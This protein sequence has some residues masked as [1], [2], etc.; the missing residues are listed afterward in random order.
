VVA[1][2][3]GDPFEEVNATGRE[4]VLTTSCL[5]IEFRPDFPNEFLLREADI[6]DELVKGATLF[7][8]TFRHD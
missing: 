7:R 6:L 2:A 8:M 1:A 5:W 3:V 4:M